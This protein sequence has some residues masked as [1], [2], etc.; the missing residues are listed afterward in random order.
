MKNVREIMSAI[1]LLIV[2]IFT[3][4]AAREILFATCT[5][6]PTT[7]VDC[8]RET[9]NEYYT[10]TVEDSKGEQWAYYDDEY[11]PIGTVLNASFN[12]NEIIDVNKGGN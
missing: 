8:V 5:P 7:V 3:L 4:L 2:L 6:Q 1:F 11:Q 9:G 10:V 12:G